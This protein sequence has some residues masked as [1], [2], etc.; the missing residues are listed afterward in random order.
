MKKQMKHF[1]KKA[2]V[3]LLVALLVT[4][5][6][7]TGSISG[8]FDVS[9]TASAVSYKSGTY[10]SFSVGDWAKSGAQ[11]V[12]TNNSCSLAVYVN[13]TKKATVSSA[14]GVYYLPTLSSGYAYKCTSVSKDQLNNNCYIKFSTGKPDGGS[15][16]SSQTSSVSKTTPS[17]TAPVPK[18]L[19]YNGSSQTLISAGST[20]GGTLQYSLDGSN[21]STSLISAVDAN[22]YPVYYRVVGNSS[23]YDVAA[24]T[25]TSIIK[26]ADPTVK[27]PDGKTITCDGTAKALVSAATTSGGTLQY[28]LNDGS[29]STSI[30]TATNV[31][32]YKIGYKVVGNNNYNDVAAQYVNSTIVRTV[33]PPVGQNLTYNT[34]PQEL[35]TAATTSAGTVYY[36]LDGQSFD[37]AIPKGTNAGDYTV[38]YKVVGYGG[39]EEVNSVPA[40]IAKADPTVVPPLGNDL[41]YTGHD[42]Q[43]IVPGSTNG[44]TL[45][46]S[47]DGQNWSTD[48]PTA[49]K[50]G[51]YPIQYRVVGDENY[52]DVPAKTVTATIT[53]APLNNTIT[54]LNI[55]KNDEPTVTAYQIITG[56][57]DS[58]GR[59]IKYVLSDK[60][61][62]YTIANF[63]EPNEDEV[64]AIASAITSKEISPMAIPMTRGDDP[65]NPDTVKFTADVEPGLYLVL[66]TNSKE[67]YVYNPAIV[68]VNVKYQGDVAEGVPGSVDMTSYFDF[69]PKAYVKSNKITVNKSIIDNE[70]NVTNGTSAAV[71]DTVRFRIDNMTIPSYSKEY[72]NPT[73]IISDTLEGAAFT[74]I[75]ELTV[76]VG[77]SSVSAGSDTFTV[78][79]KDKDGNAVE[80]KETNAAN[81]V[82]TIDKGTSFTITFNKDYLEANE[83]KSVVIDYS[84]VIADTAGYNY[85]ENQNTVKIEYSHD[86]N[87]TSTVEDTT[88]HYTFGI[89]ANV[90][91]EDTTVRRI[92]P[93]VNKVSEASDEFEEVVTEE[94]YVIV[95]NKK[96]LQ[97]AEFTIYNNFDLMDDHIVAK[98][99]SDEYGRIC[100]TGL[101]VGTYYLTET[102][103][104]EG[105]S[106]KSVIYLVQID[107]TFDEVGVLTS[108]SINT[109]L[110]D[111]NGNKGE[112]VQTASYTN[113]SYT[114]NDDGSVTNNITSDDNNTPVSIINTTLSKL[115]ST[116][117]AGTIALTI[118]ASL[119]MAVFLTMFI[120]SKKKKQK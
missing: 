57:Y 77:G 28:N 30:P 91:G 61:G 80:V 58:D 93:E 103:P 110:T 21:W 105:Y 15:T 3:F 111:A 25:V 40:K 89:S 112:S 60:L 13:G 72:K 17:V 78:T 67:G 118:F 69:P 99:I 108:Y 88:Y 68:A 49:K 87:S 26:K 44:G 76:K 100:F 23:Y 27:A 59:I 29:W 71:G 96:A 12:N 66:V 107:A 84:S 109:Y 70:G 82:M 83:G 97:G 46:Y 85:A 34:Q 52:N 2:I 47:M 20:T 16:S 101:D 14:G 56:Q 62:T 102:A 94:N 92:V 31:G 53:N 9:I 119:G 113:T 33:T 11:I 8:L 116:G 81:H 19:T 73:Y 38:Y 37:I 7:P 64:T 39:S 4:G 41:P 42:Q 43:L 54:A 104:P 117:G 10:T 95:K 98:T 32:T 86:P 120:V 79:A 22:T 90:D 48:I 115:P 63:E 55:D 114:I 18:T 45:Q 24:K 65:D 36:S 75:N 51:T 35:V 6:F 74:G 50:V 106:L 1:N 5:M